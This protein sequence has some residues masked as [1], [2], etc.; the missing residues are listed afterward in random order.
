MEP[1]G[2]II[3]LSVVA[4]VLSEDAMVTVVSEGKVVGLP[5]ESCNSTAIC[6]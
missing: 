6:L 3:S 5:E 1:A 4:I 2:I